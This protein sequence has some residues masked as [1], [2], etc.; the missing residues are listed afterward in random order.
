MSCLKEWWTR[1]GSNQRPLR[2]QGWGVLAIHQQSTLISYDFKGASVVLADKIIGISC[3]TPDDFT[4][5]L[6]KSLREGGDRG[7]R[8]APP[9]HLPSLRAPRHRARSA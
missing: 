7:S 3:V 5:L 1:L 2:C 4:I 8:N 9:S 6:T